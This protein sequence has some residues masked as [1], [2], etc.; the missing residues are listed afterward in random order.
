[1]R[2]KTDKEIEIM[3]EGGRMLATVLDVLEREIKAGMSTKDLANIAAKEIKAL[4]GRPSFLN[5]EDFPDVMT[6]SINDEIVHGIPS[7]DKKVAAGDVVGL[8][9]GV[10]YKGLVTDGARTAYIGA[11]AAGDIKRLLDGTKSALDAGI[12]AVHG[13]GT[14]VGDISSAVQDVLDKNKLGIIRDMVGHG[15][16]DELHESPNIPN[17]GV[18]GTGPKLSTG[19]TICIEPMAALGDWRIDTAKDGWTVVMHDG[20]LSAHFEHTI[21]ITEKSAEILTTT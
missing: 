21:L 13:D 9:F 1:M 14:R 2:P 15:V 11:N 19:M 6:V 18:S 3:R 16:G 8:D 17:Y 4:G 10:I 12:S 7:N 5:H 20:S